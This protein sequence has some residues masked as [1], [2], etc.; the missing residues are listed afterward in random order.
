MEDRQF[1]AKIINEL[2][3][4]LPEK[5]VWITDLQPTS[6]GKVLPMGDANKPLTPSATGAASAIPGKGPAKPPVIDGILVQGMYLHNP[7]NNNVVVDYVKALASSDYFALDM[8]N[9]QNSV[10]LDN[11]PEDPKA[12][13]TPYKLQLTFK[14]ALPIP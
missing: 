13:A 10:I 6:G 11:P 2:N 3:M 8:K 9:R 7:A 1:W 5:Y 14:K 4:R 12:W